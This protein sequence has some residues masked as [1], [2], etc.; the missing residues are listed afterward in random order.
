MNTLDLQPVL[1]PTKDKVTV[2]GIVMRPSDSR[3]GIANVLT[4][5]DP[6]S[7][8]HQHLYLVSNREI[9][10]GDW[11]AVFS[12]GTKNRPGIG[13]GWSIHKY[14]GSPRCKM[15]IL[16]G[17]KKIEFTT[18]QEL[19]AD[20]VPAVPKISY[21][22]KYS[23]PRGTVL[24]NEVLFLEEFC[25]R[26]NNANKPISPSWEDGGQKGED[27]ICPKC[28]STTIA[29]RS[30]GYI[31]CGSKTC[32]NR[33]SD[34]WPYSKHKGVDVEKLAM[35]TFPPLGEACNIDIEKQIGKRIG[36]EIGYNHALQ[37]NTGRFSLEDMR[38]YCELVTEHWKNTL[39]EGIKAGN[40]GKPNFGEDIQNEAHK[41]AIQSLTKQEQP[42]GIE[43]YCEMEEYGHGG[44]LHC[45]ESRYEKMAT[46]YRIKFIN[47]RPVIHFK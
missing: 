33:Y 36:F 14:D 1:L 11:C 16:A 6:Q 17:A 29:R 26:Y 46:F 41:R 8:I 25:K 22:E 39:S 31:I 3:L 40:H 2:N 10:E 45:Q 24:E 44:I 23:P 19:I 27:P 37:F 47:G 12:E 13:R 30:M 4:V 35:R 9:R 42:I 28:G 5:N 43:L 15:L 18:D 32:D 20:G 21:V 7:K 38:K 34:V